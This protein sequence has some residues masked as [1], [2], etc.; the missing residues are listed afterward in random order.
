MGT[1]LIQVVGVALIA[2]GLGLMWLPLGIVFAGLAV[3][4][5]G[6]IADGEPLDEGSE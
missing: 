2:V 1:V 3:F 4:G 5:L 6:W